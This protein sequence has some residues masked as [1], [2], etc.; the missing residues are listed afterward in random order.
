M[1][2]LQAGPVHG[3]R[4]HPYQ[5][6]VQIPSPAFLGARDDLLRNQPLNHTGEDTHQG[7]KEQGIHD[8]EDRVSVGDLSGGFSPYLRQTIQAIR[9]RGHP[10]HQVR[11]LPYELQPDE[12]PEDVE[13]DMD[14]CGPDGFSGFSH[15]SQQGRDAGADVRP[16]HQSDSRRKTQSP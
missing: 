4:W 10:D 1:E 11:Q 3:Q 2:D 15:G 9:F 6:R 13:E 14:G 16:E 7:Q 12:H 5:L 8:V